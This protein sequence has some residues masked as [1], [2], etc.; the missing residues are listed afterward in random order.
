MT[1]PSNQQNSRAAFAAFISIGAASAAYFSYQYLRRRKLQ[2]TLRSTRSLEIDTKLSHKLTV[3]VI[4]WFNLEK[5]KLHETP[6]EFIEKHKSDGA[7]I[8]LITDP[9]HISDIKASVTDKGVKV[10]DVNKLTEITKGDGSKVNP[11]SIIKPCLS[12]ATQKK[13]ALWLAVCSDFIR[14]TFLADPQALNQMLDDKEP[15]LSD[16]TLIYADSDTNIEFNENR[17][18]MLP[19]I[20]LD[21]QGKERNKYF[22]RN[23]LL[24]S[25]RCNR[26]HFHAILD[27]LLSKEKLNAFEQWSI[28]RD[29]TKL[30][31]NLKNLDPEENY[32]EDA[33]EFHLIA[34]LA[35]HPGKALVIDPLENQDELDSRPISAKTTQEI[36]Y[37]GNKMLFAPREIEAKLLRSPKTDQ[38]ERE[39]QCFI[40]NKDGKRKTA[41]TWKSLRQNGGL[42]LTPGGKSWTGEATHAFPELLPQQSKQAAR[43][44][45]TPPSQRAPSPPYE[46]RF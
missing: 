38:T 15:N 7:P 11:Q 31:N 37:D 45:S 29:E 32:N 13:K 42:T 27:F 5:G 17:H 22:V 8:V 46:L 10:A 39:P 4:I 9:N 6:T 1:T 23:D 36:F 43:P 41:I 14:L 33:N 34:A 16:A 21:K 2:S 40:K 30:K 28:H 18:G 44:H 12:I 26:W 35:F 20:P 19:I 3:F 25:E 24:V